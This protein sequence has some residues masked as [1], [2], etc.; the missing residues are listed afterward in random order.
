MSTITPMT[1]E[2]YRNGPENEW[3][4]RVHAALEA[5]D[6][7]AENARLGALLVRIRE[8]PNALDPTVET[9]RQSTTKVSPL[10]EQG[11]QDH[12][13]FL[14]SLL[15]ASEPLLTAAPDYASCRQAMAAEY[16]RVIDTQL[17]E[18]ELRLLKA[19]ADLAEL[20]FKKMRGLPE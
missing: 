4:R 20:E 18:A 15:K 19:R 9:G 10:T 12:L 11:L 17:H 3:T 6:V 7:N 13:A 8:H 1:A 14:D 5:A 16:T 2:E